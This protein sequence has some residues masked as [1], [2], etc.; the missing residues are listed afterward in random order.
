M[1]GVS[2]ERKS[3]RVGSSFRDKADG[4]GGRP[5]A[6]SLCASRGMD[7]LVRTRPQASPSSIVSHWIIA[8][9]NRVAKDKKVN[10]S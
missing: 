4:R 3:R 7:E 1:E 10:C 8:E 6:I 2:K 9:R 5:K